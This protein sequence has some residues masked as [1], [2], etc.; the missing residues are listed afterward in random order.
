M[1]SLFYSGLQAWIYV[2]VLDTLLASEF[3]SSYY[4]RLV[5][6]YKR[7]DLLASW[8]ERMTFEVCSTLFAG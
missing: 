5:S 1:G 3:T 4:T 8:S 6:L 7:V 2:E